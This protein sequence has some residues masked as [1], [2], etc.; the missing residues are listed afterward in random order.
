[1]TDAGVTSSAATAGFPGPD[2]A[3]SDEPAG[4]EDW[5]AEEDAPG[6]EEADGHALPLAPDA[7][8]DAALESCRCEVAAVDGDPDAENAADVAVALPPEA[9][10]FSDEGPAEAAADVA[11]PKELVGVT[12]DD[13]DGRGPPPDEDVPWLFSGL[14]GQPRRKA[15]PSPHTSALTGMER[16][17]D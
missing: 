11:P 16:I 6:A 9:D 8:A 4:D 17:A 10:A 14:G 5:G 3:G 7:K 2:E 15:S 13:E 12:D 1:M